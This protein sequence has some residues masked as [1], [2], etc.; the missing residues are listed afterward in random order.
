ME[1]GNIRKLNLK[2]KFYAFIFYEQFTINS[3][4]IEFANYKNKMFH[5]I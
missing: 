2:F 4:Q 1:N 5:P 3:N